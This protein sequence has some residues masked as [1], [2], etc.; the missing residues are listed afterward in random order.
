MKPGLLT[1]WIRGDSSF[2]TALTST[3]ENVSCPE[4]GTVA[5]AEP[6]NG[7]GTS[8][9]GWLRPSARMYS[10]C[11]R[12]IVTALLD[13]GV[14]GELV[15]PTSLSASDRTAWPPSLYTVAHGFCIEQV[16]PDVTSTRT[17]DDNV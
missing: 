9:P 4:V 2:A 1:N 3:K 12:L 6:S 10:T 11:T 17:S 5:V 8:M 14:A 13:V 7:Y 16:P 15:V